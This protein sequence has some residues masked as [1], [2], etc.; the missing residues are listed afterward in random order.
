MLFFVKI[1]ITLSNNPSSSYALSHVVDSGHIFWKQVFI[2]TTY[3][4]LLADHNA[5]WPLAQLV[6]FL[7]PFC[8]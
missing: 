6:Y 5:V 7:I 2:F 1:L 8:I 4:R 3:V